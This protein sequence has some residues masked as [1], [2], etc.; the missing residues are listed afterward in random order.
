[1][2]KTQKEIDNN[3][4]PAL[5]KKAGFFCSQVNFMEILENMI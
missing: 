3:M 5:L 2:I 1:M 4:I